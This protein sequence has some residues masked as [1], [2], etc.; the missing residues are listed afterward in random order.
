[1]EKKNFTENMNLVDIADE[2]NLEVVETT[3]QRNGYPA[4]LCRAIIGFS[5]FEEA[6]RIADE[7]GLTL[8]WIDQR[9][10][11]Q[12]WHRGDTASEPMTIK[13]DDFGDDYNFEDDADNVMEMAREVIAD[14]A[15]HATFDDIRSYMEEIGKITE[16]IEELEEDQVVVTYEGKYYDTIE[17]HPI[18]FSFD[19]KC[20]QLAA[21]K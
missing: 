12:L 4:N 17:R 9:D 6:Q 20:T 15:S 11:W 19:G 3:S 10:G 13:S 14:M 16:A 7:N 2:N 21:I 1:M 5:S 8:V 18:Y